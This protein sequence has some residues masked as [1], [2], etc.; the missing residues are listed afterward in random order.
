MSILNAITSIFKPAAELIDELHTSTDEKLAAKSRL[1]EL[2]INFIGK[3]LDYETKQTEA[4][5]AIIVA[6]ANAKGGFWGG[7]TKAWRPITMLTFLSML[8]A[9]W[10]GWIE[11]P[12]N[13]SEDVLVEIFSML[14]LG[15]GGYIGSRG[16]EKIASTAL[17]AFK[18]KDEV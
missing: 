1:S 4:K 5:S 8:V 18:K 10:F 3:A 15:I 6:E 13:A 12:V 9:W 2:Y 16:A 7:L 17:Q 11:T 14:K